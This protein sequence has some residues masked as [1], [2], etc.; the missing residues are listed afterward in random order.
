MHDATR[1]DEDVG[2]SGGWTRE[3][4]HL[5]VAVTPFLL[6]RLET[7]LPRLAAFLIA[8]LHVLPAQAQATR[9][10]VVRDV[11]PTT[12]R[13]QLLANGEVKRSATGVV[14]A[15]EAARARQHARSAVLTNA[16]VLDPKGLGD[17]TYQVLLEKQGRVTATYPATLMGFGEV[18][19]MDLGLVEVAVA[20]P[21]AALGDEETLL[22]GDELVV[23]G[24]PYGKNLSVS[25]GMVSQLQ[26]EE[27]APGTPLRY[28]AMKTDAAI[29]YGSSGGGVFHVP[30]GRLVGI[31]EGYRTARVSLGERMAFDVP[32]PGETF[33]APITKVR[34]FLAGHLAEGWHSMKAL[35]GAKTGQVTARK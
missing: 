26:A 2:A 12:V 24:A 15:S 35:A 22:L 18:P 5:P 6:S 29:G 4:A 20:L 14:V 23:V 32:M 17:V 30:S 7:S 19:D 27:G 1:A 9:A 13:V 25:G 11:V 31:V 10:Q 16:H 28:T 8:A 33:V 21:A 3:R 34:S